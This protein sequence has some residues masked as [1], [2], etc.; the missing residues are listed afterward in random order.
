GTTDIDRV[1]D[2]AEDGES[3]LYVEL[4]ALVTGE[5]DQEVAETI[6]SA[7]IRLFQRGANVIDGGLRRQLAPR[8]VGVTCAHITQVNAVRERLPD[9]LAAVEVETANRFQGL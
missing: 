3:I 5:V 2:R 9:D 4:P 8:D 7:I 6:A 1:I